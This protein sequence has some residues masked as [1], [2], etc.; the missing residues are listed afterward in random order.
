MRVVDPN[1][2]DRAGLVAGLA[3]AVQRYDGR[4][5]EIRREP[6]DADSH[7]FELGGRQNRDEVRLR[8]RARVHADLLRGEVGRRAC[9]LPLLGRRDDDDRRRDPECEGDRG[10][11]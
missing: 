2:V 7:A 4:I 6:A 5:V 11:G 3:G 9:R 1:A 10:E 8:D